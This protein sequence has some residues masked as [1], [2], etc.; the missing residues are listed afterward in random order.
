MKQDF[1]ADMMYDETNSKTEITTPEQF[2]KADL[3]TEDTDS[4][5][6]LVEI[7]AVR[8]QVMD[9][10]SFMHMFKNKVRS[11]DNID[12]KIEGIRD[13]IDEYEKAYDDE[14]ELMRRLDKEKKSETSRGPVQANS[15]TQHHME[16]YKKLQQE[17]QQIEELKENREKV[18]NQ[19][20]DLWPTAQ[21]LFDEGQPVPR[22]VE[23]ADF[24]DTTEWEV[25]QEAE[26]EE[27]ETE[28][29]EVEEQ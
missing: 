25:E 16:A 8:T 26:E 13:G 17:E 7:E 23:N 11:I 1:S 28:N 18:M 10:E 5:D 24:L 27:V 6:A 3:E 19:I 20:N 2:Q 12:Q 22:E 21:E 9:V 29:E 15:L 4:E 14:M